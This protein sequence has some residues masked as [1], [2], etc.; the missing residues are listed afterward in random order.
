MH[1]LVRCRQVPKIQTAAAKSE[2]KQK[3][4]KPPRDAALCM[5]QQIL[6]KPPKTKTLEAKSIVDRV[7]RP[8]SIIRSSRSGDRQRQP[9][10][11][12]F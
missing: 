6:Q 2:R 9:A 3:K 11:Q 4:S 5:N 12:A 1:R 7:L 10:T 8:E